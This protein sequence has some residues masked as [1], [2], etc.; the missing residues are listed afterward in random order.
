MSLYI[1]FLCN[2]LEVKFAQ[3]RTFVESNAIAEKGEH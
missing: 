3:A 1:S 2:K